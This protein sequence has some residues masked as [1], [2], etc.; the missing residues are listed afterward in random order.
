MDQVH[1]RLEVQ[2]IRGVHD[3]L[4]KRHTISKKNE[5]RIT[6]KGDLGNAVYGAL[7]WAK[8]RPLRHPRS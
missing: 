5:F 7:E 3:R 1:I 8:D 4:R 6:R 2:N